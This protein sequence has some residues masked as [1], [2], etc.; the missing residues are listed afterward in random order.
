LNHGAQKSLKGSKIL[1]LG[2]A[3]KSDIDDVRESPA[4]KVLELLETAGADVAYHDTFVPEFGGKRSSPLEPENYD[5][6]V[7]VTAHSGIDYGDVVKRG[8]VI[9]D[10]RNATKGHEIDGKVWKL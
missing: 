10:F 9:V 8:K 7:I 3:Y 2:V 4:E 6:V 5:C 1:I